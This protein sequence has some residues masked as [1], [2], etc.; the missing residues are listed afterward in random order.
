MRDRRVVISGT[1]VISSLGQTTDTFWESCLR[2]VTVV[3]PIPEHWWDYAE[4]KSTIWSPL[5]EIDLADRGIN[6]V[7]QLELDPVSVITICAAHEA[8]SNAGLN[9]VVKDNRRNSYHIENCDPNSMGVYMGTGVGGANSFLE[10]HY[11]SILARSRSVLTQLAESQNLTQRDERIVNAVI[12]RMYH[13]RRVNPFIV[14]MLMPNAVSAALGLKYSINGPNVTLTV[15]C[16]SG[17]VAIGRAFQAIRD[18]VVDLALT[19]GA[20]YLDDH[21]GYIFRGFDVGGTLVRDCRNPA[22]ANRPFDVKHSGFLF[23]QGAAGVLILE[24][25]EHAKQRG[26]PILAEVSGYSE[27]F[28][29]HSVMSLASD[30]LQIERMIR[31]VVAASGLCEADIQYVNA[32]GTATQNNDDIEASVLLRVFGS[33]PIVNSTKS[34]LGH[35]IGASGAL[36][37][38]VTALSLQRQIAHVSRNLQE[39]VLDL[40]FATSTTPMEINAALT[41]SFAFGGH[42]AALVFERYPL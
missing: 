9:A 16:A 10:N 42:N 8:L 28:D 13:L 37:A 1:G 35:T 29:A 24:E 18:G 26:A 41:Q 14:S 17:T 31:E 30:G 33:E 38:V 15:A 3:S 21:Y 20:E 6:R 23:S 19:G 27:T 7:E 11:H 39:P 12:E 5:P 36:E 2:G 34:L 40:N 22:E 32:H 25:L 4:Y